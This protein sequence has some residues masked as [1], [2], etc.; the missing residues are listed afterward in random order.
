CNPAGG[1][2]GNMD[3]VSN[4]R[5]ERE[6]SGQR[7]LRCAQERAAMSPCFE[8]GSGDGVH[9]GLL[10]RCGLLGC[11]RGSDG[12][13]SLGSTL[14]QD[15]SWRN[16]KNEAEHRDVCIDQ[17]TSLIFKSRAGQIW[18]VCW[19]RRSQLCEMAGNWDKASVECAFVR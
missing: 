13:N 5:N 4:L 17:R 6:R 3:K 9:A 1:D 8:A 15:F 19:K 10:E 14:L 7:I 2:H 11:C 16:P 18:F 12:Y